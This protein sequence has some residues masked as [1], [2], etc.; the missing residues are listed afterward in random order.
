MTTDADDVTNVARMLD[1][2]RDII[3][4]PPPR[5]V[6]ARN[7]AWAIAHAWA[8][9]VIARYGE[10][11]PDDVDMPTCPICR[12]DGMVYTPDTNY[13]HCYACSYGCTVSVYSVRVQV[14][15][16]EFYEPTDV[17]Y[18]EDEDGSPVIIFDIR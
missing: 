18:G 5:G 3:A 14:D 2:A 1:K 7:L 17:R 9:D 11:D 15:H 12:R 4:N 6:G 16:N 13:Y 10:S 8:L